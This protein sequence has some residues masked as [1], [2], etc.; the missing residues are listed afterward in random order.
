LD[1]TG[2][3]EGAIAQLN[4]FCRSAGS[5]YKNECC[6]DRGYEKYPGNIS[7]FHGLSPFLA[8]ILAKKSIKTL[9]D[10]HLFCD[11]PLSHLFMWFVFIAPALC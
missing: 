2:R 5:I 11:P 7:Q 3:K 4:C 9:S 10:R 6:Q 8:C 1:M